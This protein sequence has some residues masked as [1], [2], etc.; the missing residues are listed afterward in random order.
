MITVAKPMRVPTLCPISVR[1]FLAPM[2][3]NSCLSDDETKQL[4][5][6]AARTIDLSVH[7]VYVVRLHPTLTGHATVCQHH[8]QT[9][10]PIDDRARYFRSARTYLQAVTRSLLFGG[11]I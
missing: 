6:V 4:L 1:Y 10:N 3:C 7:S 11:H 5:C 8:Y 2:T 9:I